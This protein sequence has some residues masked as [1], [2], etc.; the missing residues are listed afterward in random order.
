MRHEKTY[1]V[2]ELQERLDQ[3][4][5]LLLID[6]IGLT[7]EQFGE[8]RARLSVAGARCTV[9]KNTFIKQ[10]AR[11]SGLPDL[12]ENLTGQTA[13][14][15]GESD[16]C[17][18][19]KVLKNFASEFDKPAVKVGVLRGGLLTPEDVKSLADLPSREILLA[20][21]LG[22]LQ[23]PATKLARVL[24]EPATAFARLLKAKAEQGG[25]EG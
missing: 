2:S 23:A 22:V 25:G 11:E 21:L 4:P 1:I 14:V 12:G 24:N 8:L 19:A 10:A 7:V 3:S 17:A 20:Q 18:A 9:V 13:I 16:V 5:F 15:T 6:Y